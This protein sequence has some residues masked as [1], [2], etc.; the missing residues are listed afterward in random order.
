MLFGNAHEFSNSPCTGP[1]CNGWV[2]STSETDVGTVTQ[3]AWVTWITPNQ[4]LAA[5]EFWR[6]SALAALGQI[7]EF[8]RDSRSEPRSGN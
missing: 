5:I 2:E 3:A 1:R 4:E 7:I 8:V 6:G